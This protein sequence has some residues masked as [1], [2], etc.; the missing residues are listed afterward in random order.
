MVIISITISMS[1]IQ[2]SSSL[3]TLQHV[4]LSANLRNLV[5]PGKFQPCAVVNTVWLPAVDMPDPIC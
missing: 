3:S 2:F 1:M 4:K 5:K